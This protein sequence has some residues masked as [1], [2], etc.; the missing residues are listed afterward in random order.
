VTPAVLRQRDFRLLLAGSAISRVGSQISIVALPLIAVLVLNASSFQLGFLTAAETAAFLLVGL[1]AGAW[2]DRLPHLPV[3]I[4]SD[5]VRFVCVGTVPLAGAFGLL[6]MTQLYV[7]ALCMGVATVFFDVTHQSVLPGIVAAD[8]LVPANGALSAV[9][10]SAEVVGPGLAGW[11]YQLLGGPLA[12]L[13][14]AVSYLASALALL[15]I[16]AR[17]PRGAGNPGEPLRDRIAEGLRFVFGN[18]QLRA[19][20]LTTAISNL[21]AAMLFAVQVAFWVRTLRL[22]PLAVGVLLSVSAVGGLLA[23]LTT[24]R[25]SSAIGGTRVI[26]LSV[27]VSAPFSLLWPLSAV[28]GGA[29]V[30]GLGSLAI[31]YGSIAF[32]ITQLSLRQ[33]LCPPGLLGRMNATMRFLAWGVMPIGALAGGAIGGWAGN[34]A[35][36]GVCAVLF[37]LSPLPL[38]FSPLRRRPP[39]APRPEPVDAF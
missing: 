26:L 38:V 1:P 12:V 30:F 16:R 24:G 23:A 34:P 18:P 20:S 6:T 35:A 25:L 28:T 11:L 14:D 7:V 5:L 4:V 21:A 36:V 33:T 10:S 19:I 15:R 31:W 22:S 27:V 3:L 32:N 2:I 9:T 37:L 17:P 29:V 13:L 8:Q 39:V